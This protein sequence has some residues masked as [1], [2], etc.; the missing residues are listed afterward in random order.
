MISPDIKL[1]FNFKALECSYLLC[2]NGPAAE[3]PQHLIMHVVVCIHSSDI[4]R[5]L[6]IVLWWLQ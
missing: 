6:Q 4:E 1:V 3:Q 2:I 5:V